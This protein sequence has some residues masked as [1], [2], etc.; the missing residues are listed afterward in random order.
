MELHELAAALEITSCTEEMQ[1]FYS[2]YTPDGIPACDLSL[3]DRL[4]REY[5]LFGK[6]FEAVKEAACQ[7]NADPNRSAW[8]KFGS[9]YI[10][11]H[12]RTVA[13]KF[14]LPPADGT[15]AGD[16]LP[17]FILLPQIPRSLD[18][19]RRRGFGEGEI[20]RAAQSYRGGISVVEE[21]TGRP[22]IN[23]LYF[24]WLMHYIKA[25]IF[26]CHSLQF[27]LHNLPN[28]A[29]F[30]KNRRTGEV[31]PVATTGTF[32]A[33]GIQILGS[34]GYTDPEGAFTV[35]LEEDEHAFR[36]HGVYN[37]VVSAGATEFLKEEWEC[38]LRPG[39]RC[40]GVH[41][42]RGADI[43]TEAIDRSLDE[44]RRVLRER[45][46][47]FESKAFFCS[48]WLLDP[49]LKRLLGPNAKISG[50]LSRFV[51]APQKSA[52]QHVFGNV[53]AKNSGPLEDLPE[54]TTLRRLLKQF[55]LD[56]HYIY[57]YY[58]VIV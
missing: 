40:L 12:D 36:G 21:Q 51:C 38:I 33:S 11:A 20:A 54:D 57:A 17:L 58:G 7:I 42:P 8:V 27:E 45:Y 48:S 22:G 52:G 3:I 50:F 18:E 39:D 31:L 23:K 9:A 10:A 35:R 14:V 49:S 4:Q 47:E 2:S 6:Y 43:S 46:P 44:A 53:F 30:L 1:E 37:G 29:V 5:E 32:H 28:K 24:G 15:P 19:Y 55:Y 41:I 25:D 56:G 13:G 26:K 34:A 16:L